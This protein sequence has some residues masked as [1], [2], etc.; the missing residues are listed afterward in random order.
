MNTANVWVDEVR[1]LW[2]HSAAWMAVET[3]A[4]ELVELVSMGGSEGGCGE[5]IYQLRVVGQRFCEFERAGLSV[6]VA[7]GM[8]SARARTRGAKGMIDG[9]EVF[10]SADHEG[11]AYDC[12]NSTRM[13]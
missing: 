5:E 8:M 12:N 4:G 10:G 1:V 13:G 2:L 11:Q 6:A 7:D 9:D 3:V